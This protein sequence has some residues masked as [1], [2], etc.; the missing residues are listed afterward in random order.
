M[1]LAANTSSKAIVVGVA[2]DSVAAT[3][4]VNVRVNL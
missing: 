2:L 3:E 4:S 1:P